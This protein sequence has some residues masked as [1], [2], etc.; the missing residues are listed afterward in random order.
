MTG[1]V[2]TSVRVTQ[3][4]RRYPPE[5]RRY[6]E[7]GENDEV[8]AQQRA[9]LRERARV[10]AAHKRK[11]LA[12][13]PT[14]SD[15][16]AVVRSVQQ[17][18]TDG[19]P[20][21]DVEGRPSPRRPLGFILDM[22]VGGANCTPPPDTGGKPG[23]VCVNAVQLAGAL[24][25]ELGYPVRECNVFLAQSRDPMGSWRGAMYQEAALQVWI[26]A[27]WHWVDP[28][29]GIFDPAATRDDASVYKADA[30][31]YWEGVVP[32]TCWIPEV[33][34]RWRVFGDGERLGCDLQRRFFPQR[35]DAYGRE[36]P[37]LPDA[38]VQRST[39][40]AERPT[41]TTTPG[42]FIRSPDDDVRLALYDSAG[43]AT[44]HRR[45]E[46][47]GS[48]HIAAGRTVSG[49]PSL[50]A[51][52]PPMRFRNGESGFEH[53]ESVFFGCVSI[54]GGWEDVRTHQLTLVVNAEAHRQLT[55]E[56]EIVFGEH[57]VTLDGLPQSVTTT[58][59][60]T[61][62][63]F[64]VT[65]HPIDDA[66]HVLFDLLVRDGVVSPRMYWPA[67]DALQAMRLA[68]D[69]RSATI[70]FGEPASG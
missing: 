39:S 11:E 9:T 13:A 36:A 6:W 56:Q 51:T 28:Y 59:D 31:Y 48:V 10:A 12:G 65:I 18:V 23:W 8:S 17:F 46:V 63:D 67:A 53:F 42:V 19:M 24:L 57:L 21:G 30:P 41:G 32:P 5:Q 69:V 7:R 25:R 55:L 40:A 43:R 68:R 58:G 16:G 1:A 70:G 66:F 33:D 15:D 29:L 64:S 45:R 62:I 2:P 22:G 3:A 20:R 50:P 60:E 44:D 38:R 35:V 4:Y 61:S 47:P 37:V 14:A 34:P 27:G 54:L 26:D 49:V 52:R